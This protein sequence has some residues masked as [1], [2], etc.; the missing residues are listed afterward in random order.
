[1]NLKL[2]YMVSFELGVGSLPRERPNQWFTLL[3]AVL[4]PS[5]DVASQRVARLA[6]GVQALAREDP[7]LPFSHVQPTGMLWRVVEANPTHVLVVFLAQTAWLHRHRR[8]R[9]LTASQIG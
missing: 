1:M 2:R 7:D 5:L 3:V 8:A 9:V 6:S 4:F